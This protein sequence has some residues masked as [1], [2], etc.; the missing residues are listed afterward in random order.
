MTGRCI[1]RNRTLD[2]FFAIERCREG[3]D[4]SLYD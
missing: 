1:G 3:Y 2:L 4:Y